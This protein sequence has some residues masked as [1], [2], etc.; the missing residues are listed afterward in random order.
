MASSSLLGAQNSGGQ[1]S[2]LWGPEMMGWLAGREMRGRSP[3]Q[4]FRVPCLSLPHLPLH[5][6]HRGPCLAVRN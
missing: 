2:A 3:R 1:A 6:A 4:G 5:A